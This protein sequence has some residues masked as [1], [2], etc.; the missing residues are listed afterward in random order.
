MGV[1]GND[2]IAKRLIEDKDS[3]YNNIEVPERIDPFSI[4][5][6]T[7]SEDLTPD[8]PDRAEWY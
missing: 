2:D 3:G 1:I 5:E 6:N 4:G 8:N 7:E